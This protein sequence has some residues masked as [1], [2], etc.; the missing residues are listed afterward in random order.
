MRVL[1]FGSLPPA[2]P[3]SD[4]RGVAATL[5]VHSAAGTAGP[6]GHSSQHA[7]QHLAAAAPAGGNNNRAFQPSPIFDSRQQKHLPAHTIPR[8]R[9]NPRRLSV[10]TTHPRITSSSRPAAERGFSRHAITLSPRAINNGRW[11]GQVLGRQELGGQ[12]VGRGEQEAAESLRAGGPPGTLRDGFVASRVSFL[13][14]CPAPTLDHP[15]PRYPE[16]AF[17]GAGRATAGTS[18]EVEILSAADRACCPAR[19]SRLRRP[20]SSPALREKDGG[21][22]AAED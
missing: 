22:C 14:R 11:Q 16:R 20:R 5:A 19:R 8:A 18:C 15:H 21:F 17:R 3:L 1:R 6:A 4:G 2:A 10:T 7:A 13:P 12:D 9:S